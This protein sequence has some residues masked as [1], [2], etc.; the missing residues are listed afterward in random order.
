M[1][2][3]GVRMLIECRK[4]LV[5]TPDVF[6]IY[7]SLQTYQTYQETSTM[8]WLDTSTSLT[9]EPLVDPTET[10]TQAPIEPSDEPIVTTTE[11]PTEPPTE[12]PVELTDAP[13]EAS[14]EAPAEPTE[15]TTEPWTDL[16]SVYNDC[17]FFKGDSS[18]FFDSGS[19]YRNDMR[20]G[21]LNS[22]HRI[23]Q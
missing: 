4:P 11:P 20:H 12:L 18:A 22:N 10:T 16:S 1:T 9:T 14:T 7:T 23:F 17:Q 19:P 8:E 15:A 5:S 2:E 3:S 21:L 6:E 13:T